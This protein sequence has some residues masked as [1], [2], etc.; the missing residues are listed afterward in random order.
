MFWV[1]SKGRYR[2][3]EDSVSWGVLLLLF[4]K[5]GYSSQW[6]YIKYQCISRR[7]IWF[8]CVWFSP[9]SNQDFI[10]EY[11]L[12]M[13]GIGQPTFSQIFFC[14]SDYKILS[15]DFAALCHKKSEHLLPW[16][17]SGDVTYYLNMACIEVGKW[18]EFT[19]TY[20]LFVSWFECWDSSMVN[21]RWKNE[22]V[23][24]SGPC[25]V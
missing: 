25:G 10:P 23:I 15:N 1:S 22:F 8:I 14:T 20:G 5:L 13:F 24:L 16:V 12:K 4:W 17:N 9:S 18:F 21:V 11:I 19:Q 7:C 6:L 3:G 2:D